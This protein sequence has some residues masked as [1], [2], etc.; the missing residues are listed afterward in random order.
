MHDWSCKSFPASGEAWGGPSPALRGRLGGGAPPGNPVTTP[1]PCFLSTER[2]CSE[3][4]QGLPCEIGR[5]SQ[6]REKAEKRVVRRG[7]PP[8]S[9]AGTGERR[10]EEG[11]GTAVPLL[12]KGACTS[13]A[14]CVPNLSGEVR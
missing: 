11:H 5:I 13:R 6:G 14:G 2:V 7:D 4:E 8:T 9:P 1:F 10:L 12:T 3:A